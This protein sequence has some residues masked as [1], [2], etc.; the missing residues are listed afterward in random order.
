MIGYLQIQWDDK[1]LEMMNVDPTDL[2]LNFLSQRFGLLKHRKVDG[3][4]R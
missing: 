4:V 3:I 1:F 2:L